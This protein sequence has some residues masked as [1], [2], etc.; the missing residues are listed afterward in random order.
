MKEKQGKGITGLDPSEYAR[1]ASKIKTMKAELSQSSCAFGDSSEKMSY[2]TTTKSAL[3]HSA[4]SAGQKGVKSEMPEVVKGSAIYFGNTPPDYTSEMKRSTSAISV[5][6]PDDYV[7]R[8][9]EVATMKQ[10]LLRRNFNLG[11][12]PV[13]YRSDYQRGF[14]PLPPD[15]YKQSK[16][17]EMKLFLEDIKKCHFTLG[18]DKVVYRSNTDY[19]LEA[20]ASSTP[21]DVR[22]Q[23]QHARELKLKLQKTSFVIGDD[24]DYR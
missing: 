14:A 19:A 21:V 13:E 17:E 23:I 10:N 5:G 18:S 22:K 24:E 2:D 1:N 11:D 12:E 20:G 8:R 15:S 16:T 3:R 7:K 6:E 9:A 4:K